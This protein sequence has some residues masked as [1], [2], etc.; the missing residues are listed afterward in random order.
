M[1]PLGQCYVL[2]G[3]EHPNRQT[4][5]YKHRQAMYFD[6]ETITTEGGMQEPVLLVCSY[7]DKKTGKYVFK[8]FDNYGT[9]MND[10]VDFLLQVD[11]KSKKQMR[12]KIG[13]KKSKNFKMVTR[14]KI[15]YLFQSY[16][17]VAHNFKGFDSVFVMNELQKHFLYKLN[18]IYAGSKLQ[19]LRVA[20]PGITFIDSLNFVHCSLRNLCKMFGLQES[21]TFFP[22]SLLTEIGMNY[23][24]ELPSVDAYEIN[25]L[26]SNERDEFFEFYEKQ[27][28]K[29]SKKDFILKKELYDYC[30][31]DVKVLAVCM[32]KFRYLIKKETTFD[33]FTRDITLAGICLRDFL[34]NH[35]KMHT[36]GIIPPK[37][38]FKCAN[39]SD[40]AL[41][42]LC[43]E[44]WKMKLTASSFL[45]PE[46]SRVWSSLLPKSFRP[47]GCRA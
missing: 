33:P 32:E 46:P 40:K 26:K 5:T 1:H 35:L 27:R 2:T 25:N 37:G 14:K 18:M 28:I 13:G 43:F 15:K 22:Y 19:T 34:N 9:V 20:G 4:I 8:S 7:I 36:L 29:F 39:Q 3:K 41:D 47:A 11:P 12:R 17:V 44:A 38:Y 21:K 23:R 42:Y 24:G 10:F 31:Q 6:I 45:I 30:R 16:V